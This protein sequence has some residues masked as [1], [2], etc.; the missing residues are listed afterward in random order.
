MEKR[1]MVHMDRRLFN[2][3]GEY[4][5]IENIIDLLTRRKAPEKQ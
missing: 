5:Q 4:N 3:H 2:L 1:F